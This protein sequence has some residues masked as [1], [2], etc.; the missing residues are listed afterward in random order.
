MLLIEN[1][2][3]HNSNMHHN[4]STP[5]TTM[6]LNQLGRGLTIC[7]EVVFRKTRNWYTISIEDYAKNVNITGTWCLSQSRR[8]PPLFGGSNSKFVSVGGK[9]MRKKSKRIFSSCI[10]SYINMEHMWMAA[11]GVGGRFAAA[12]RG[13]NGSRWYCGNGKK[14]NLRQKNLY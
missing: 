6:L 2:I 11:A 14:K 7:V 3:F 4:C 1:E 9:S 8:L 5:F 12:D 13:W 10:V